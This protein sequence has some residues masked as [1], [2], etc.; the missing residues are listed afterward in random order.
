MEHWGQTAADFDFT[1]S[2]RWRRSVWKS[3]QVRIGCKSRTRRY[4]A[5]HKYPLVSVDLV[6]DYYLYNGDVT[7]LRVEKFKALYDLQKDAA[8]PNYDL[9]V[10]SVLNLDEKVGP[11]Q[12]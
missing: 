6:A 4:V 12:Y 5:P 10:L 7:S 2:R 1:T 3:Q 11:C 8:V 9:D